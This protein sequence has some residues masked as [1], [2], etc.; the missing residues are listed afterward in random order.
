M[1]NSLVRGKKL[2]LFL[3]LLVANPYAYAN[4]E[5]QDYYADSVAGYVEACL[6]CHLADGVAD[7]RGARLI[8]SG[9]GTNQNQ[10]NAQTIT[11]FFAYSDVDA[12]LILAKIS[13]GASHG[14]AQVYAKGSAGYSA[15][16]E[17]LSLIAG[18]STDGG[19]DGAND[20][21][22]GLVLEPPERTLRRA[23]IL[24]GGKL[25]KNSQYNYVKKSDANLRSTVLKFMKGD[26]F[27]SFL[28]T[29]A[30][31][32]LHTE[33]FNNGMTFEFGFEGDY[34]EANLWW[35]LDRIATC[36][37]IQNN[38]DPSDEF[39]ELNTCSLANTLY[40]YGVV[41]AP[42]ELIAYIVER[43]LSYKQVVTAKYSM[44]NQFTNNVYRSGA[45]FPKPKAGQALEPSQFLTYKKGSDRGQANY[46]GAFEGD[47]DPICRVKN[48]SG[49]IN[50][51][52]AGVLTEPAW[53][54][55]YPTTDT[56]RNRARARWT[57]YHFLGVDIEKSAPRTTDAVALSDNDNPTMKNPACTVCHE[58][59]DPVAGAYQNFGD[60]GRYRSKG[61]TDSLA[62]AYK[63]PEWFGGDPADTPY[64]EGDVW[65]RDMRKPGISGKTTTRKHGSLQWL[66]QEIVKDPRFA[67]AA[68]AFWW[69][70]IMGSD[71]LLAPEQSTDQ[72]Y[73]QKL[74]AYNAQQAEM[75]SLAQKFRSKGYRAK[76]LFAD[77]VLSPWF[78]AE[79]FEGVN[80]QDR[81]QE[82]ATVG[83]GRLLTPEELDRKAFAIFGTR[84]NEQNSN[85]W[86]PDGWTQLS[87]GD[88]KIAYGGIDSFGVLDRA[89]ELTALMS[90]VAERQAVEFACRVTI[91][92]FNR[93][94]L[95]DLREQCAKDPWWEDDWEKLECGLAAPDHRP[96]L[97]GNVSKTTEPG[98]ANRAKIETQIVKLY[99]V[100]L[101][102]KV[103]RAHP[104]VK[105]LYRLLESRWKES[106]S[107]GWAD[108]PC[109]LGSESADPWVWDQKHDPKFMVAAWSSV[110][111]AL[112]T[113]YWYLHD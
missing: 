62:E 43:N 52:H 95:P 96:V 74:N 92:D 59:M 15:I 55:R 112:M 19:P 102:Q 107:Q 100:V 34:P 36:Q 13:G 113:H 11:D 90:N 91:Y 110:M 75:D 1:I 50:R 10:M 16:D 83:S 99:D 61:G 58:R 26:E 2:W 25:P 94:K 85:P 22:R 111:R 101:G 57:F 29:G 70:A 63:Y 78:R 67:R 5:V 4:E 41:R 38:D 68:V 86:D 47:C 39:R 8:L 60:F 14:G 7:S 54:A 42:V 103:T 77:M 45:A 20:F 40:K 81:M 56:N 48:F 87:K 53:L 30:D 28:I 71:P 80:L 73:Q 88:E 76:Q 93:E 105:E 24:F 84:W 109:W 64:Q 49:Y 65:Y 82:L 79:G 18:E 97:F 33:A 6:A 72:D 37:E 98:D 31:D 12:A 89:R 104:E 27:H 3:S 9:S 69:P 51:P 46:L 66:G 108:N 21:W 32:R 106:N 44:V 35:E 17:L 23:A